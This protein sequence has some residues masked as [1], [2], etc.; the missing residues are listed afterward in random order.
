[1]TVL[2][3]MSRYH[4][5][6]EAVKRTGC[7]YEGA[8]DFLNFCQKK[9]QEHREYICQYLDDMPDIKNWKWTDKEIALTI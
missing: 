7:M 8:Q 9:L 6:Y 3:N 2:N 5:A 1:M 4:L